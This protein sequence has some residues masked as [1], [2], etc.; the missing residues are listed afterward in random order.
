MRL[1]SVFSCTLSHA[2]SFRVGSLALF[3]ALGLTII[4]LPGCGTTDPDGTQANA[5]AYYGV[6]FND[7]WYY[8]PDYYPPDVIVTPPPSR[9]VDPPHVEQPIAKPPP[10]ARPLPSFP[11]TP[12]PAFRR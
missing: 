2:C 8:G 11:A 9:P 5:S 1:G 4:I 10:A 6:G 7:P 12:R 3:A